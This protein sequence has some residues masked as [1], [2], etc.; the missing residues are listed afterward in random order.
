MDA[1]CVS[2]LP[3][4]E[5]FS[6][7]SWTQSMCLF[8]PRERLSALNHGRSLC[9]DTSRGKRLSLLK[10][11]VM[12]CPK[13]VMDIILP[14]RPMLLPGE[15][16]NTLERGV[17]PCAWCYYEPTPPFVFGSWSGGCS[18]AAAAA[19]AARSCSLVLYS[20]ITYDGG[21]RVTIMWISD[22]YGLRRLR[23]GTPRCGVARRGAALV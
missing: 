5:T 15:H 21:G 16:W 22:F 18:V 7:E 14:Q 13:L 12:P 4:R 10:N 17:S 6:A 8:S 9:V 3:A 23:R 2:I 11:V 20:A 1:V 19:D